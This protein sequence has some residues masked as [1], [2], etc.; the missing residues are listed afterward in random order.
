MRA[1]SQVAALAILLGLAFAASAQID[2]NIETA[3]GEIGGQRGEQNS[4]VM[5]YLG[6][7][8]AVP[9]VGANRWR[10][11]EP[12]A[13]FEKRFRAN[14][15]G[16]RCMQQAAQADF[17]GRGF[18]SVS[19]PAGGGNLAGQFRGGGGGFGGGGFGRGAGGG[20]RGGPGGFGLQA[21]PM[22][23][24]CLTLNIWS[25]VP[26][27]DARQPV[28]VFVHG[29]GLVRG[30]AS[31]AR[32]SGESLA[33]R[34]IVVVN[35]NYRLGA[36]GFLAHPEI[37]DA[38][39]A[40]GNY[41][42]MDAIAALGWIARNIEV[43]GGDPQDVTVVGAAEGAWLTAAMIGSPQAKGL[44]QR[45]I[46]QSAG[47][48]GTGMSRL[49]TSAQ[50]A[51]DGAEA[52]ARFAGTPLREIPAEDLVGVLPKPQLVIDG[53]VIPEDLS[54][55]FGRGEQNA[56]DVIVG[57]NREEG[58]ALQEQSSVRTAAE[59]EAAARERFGSLAD[60]YL[61]LYPSGSDEEAI[62]SSVTALGDELAWE[63]RLMAIA[64]ASIGR[65][66][67][68]YAFTRVPPA[69]GAQASRGAARGAELPYV[70][71]NMP[72]FQ[73]WSDGDRLLADVIS[74]YWLVFAATG[75][76]NIEALPPWPPYLGDEADV[77]E[78]GDR[79]DVDASW[80]LTPEK[81]AFFDDA[82]RALMSSN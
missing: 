71:T 17:G 63:T 9:P 66:G 12:L 26:S 82:Y 31:D 8:Y 33:G 47:W 30:A 4:D 45:A 74:T 39:G 22:D 29:D 20:F 3:A 41:G 51:A 76:P 38:A 37:A 1:S 34:G 23:E 7:P 69:I 36:F 78:L 19:S 6:I 54:R 81:M 70:L 77:M 75:N 48:M 21:V 18:G 40:S 53:G 10:P 60:R 15:Y 72:D 16:P 32:F 80:T 56:V 79:V 25:G 58:I 2:R 11:P 28:L 50:A 57:S 65:N 59:Y 14:E 52:L 5:S 43:F 55:I 73:P 61:S 42:L 62:I 67:Y 35:F 46:L 13:P 49:S 68:V 24:D 64:Q 27:A 44:F